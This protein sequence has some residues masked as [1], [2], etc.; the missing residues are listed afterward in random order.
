M[1]DVRTTRHGPVISDLGRDF[2]GTPA[3]G[4]GLVLAARIA[5]LDGDNR[6]ALGLSLL[7]QA[8]DVAAA[9]RAA[10]SITAPVQNLLVADSRG[11]ALFTTGRVPLRRSGDGTFPVPG[12]DG[13]HDWTGYASGL[14]L[15]RVVAPASGLLLNAN[16]PVSGTASTVFMGRDAPEAWRARRIAALLSTASRFS[17]DDFAS[18]QGDVRD[19]FLVRLVP[20]LLA[21]VS[22]H[23]ELSSSALRE[24]AD[25]DG[26][27]SAG[28]PEPL[29]AAAWL[30]AVAQSVLRRAGD[31][32]GAASRPA[33]LVSDALTRH[34]TVLCGGP[35]STLLSTTL[36][37]TVA[38]IAVS[39]G[40]NPTAWQWG[41]VHRAHF[42]NPLWGGLPLLGRIGG[43][44]LA[45]GGDAETI[46][47]QGYAS[48]RFASVHGASFRGVYD[49]SDLDA[50]RFVIATGESGN[51]FS[52]HLLDF[53]WRWQHVRTVT[54]G[55]QPATVSATLELN[56]K[57]STP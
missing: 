30:R 22:A 33:A 43:A 40:G 15:P 1:L 56:A 36:Q 29:I 18:M 28:R 42:R 11:I 25:W 2:G 31:P 51:P 16:E 53:G 41:H 4:P 38:A 34:D 47:A 48:E 20:H 55:P 27:M 9:G 52:R 46:D 37:R 54:L 23:D 5:S 6:A 50:S 10:A 3:P 57:T 39:Q 7:N 14:A 21:G 24:L 45:V 19:L 8:G 17:P 32:E 44:D 13:A 49:L 26:S 12:W 35:C